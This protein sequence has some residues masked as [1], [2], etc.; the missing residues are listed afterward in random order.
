MSFLLGG[1]VK[2]DIDISPIVGPERHGIA[3]KTLVVLHET[4]SPDYPGSSEIIST[5]GYMARNGL[6]IHGVI[7]AE[8][9]FGWAR[10]YER[11]IF[12]HAASGNG[13]VNTRAI[14]IE[15]VSRVM[16]DKKD[17]ASRFRT[18]W[19]RNKQI[20]KTAQALA[21]ISHEHGIPLIYSEA[22]YD[23]PGI[24]THWQVSETWNVAGGHWDCWPKHVG[25][26]F[27][28]MRII[29]RARQLKKKYGWA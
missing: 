14:G 2:A 13:M 15:L 28:A 17:N 26:Y 27:P 5:A 9:Y 22:G 19:E 25:G 1:K 4:V 12:Y 3:K 6:G 8:G 18:W 11:A 20:E 29:Y 21:Y 10:D 16:L 24:T 23:E 7:D